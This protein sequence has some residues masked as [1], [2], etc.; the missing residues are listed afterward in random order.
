[1][2]YYIISVG[3]DASDQEHL[4]V[5]P[6][7][8]CR[9]LVTRLIH[10][11]H[12]LHDLHVLWCHRLVTTFLFR[13]A[14]LPVM[15]VLKLLLVAQGYA[16]IIT[17]SQEI[18]QSSSPIYGDRHKVACLVQD[19]VTTI[20]PVAEQ[21]MKSCATVLAKNL[22]QKASFISQ[23]KMSNFFAYTFIMFCPTAFFSNS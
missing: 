21:R 22:T 8:S 12:C 6:I 14:L 20:L 1:M 11:C 23:C 19:A 16:F 2:Q 10:V 9:S 15:K 3:N 7:V 13:A 18:K 4:F 5:I 17:V